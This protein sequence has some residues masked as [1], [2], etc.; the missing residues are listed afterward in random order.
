MHF[1][2]AAWLASLWQLAFGLRVVIQGEGRALVPAWALL[3]GQLRLCDACMD[4]CLGTVASL[5]V[6]LCAAPGHNVVLAI[7]CQD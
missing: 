1:P 3:K 4:A 5:E 7:M 6:A 2:S